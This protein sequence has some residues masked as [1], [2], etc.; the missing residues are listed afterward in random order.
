MVVIA[1]ESFVQ[2]TLLFLLGGENPVAAG[3][4]FAGDFPKGVSI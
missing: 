3:A 1:Q 4:A 2:V